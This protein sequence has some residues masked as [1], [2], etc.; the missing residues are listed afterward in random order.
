MKMMKPNP[1]EQA[2]LNELEAV[3]K[4][5]GYKNCTARCYYMDDS[6]ILVYI[7]SERIGLYDLNKHAFVSFK[8]ESL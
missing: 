7:Y 6:R 3:L 2:D 1:K 5:M 8:K 4:K